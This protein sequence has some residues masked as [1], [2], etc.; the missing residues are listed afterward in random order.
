MSARDELAE[1]YEQWRHWTEEEGMA[2]RIASWR[3]VDECQAAKL[4]LQRLIVRTT[5]Q[6]HDD[7]VGLPSQVEANE[8]FFRRIIDGLI[9][10]ER[11]NLELFANQRQQA[12]HERQSLD[13]TTRH[14]RQIHRSYVRDHSLTEH[15]RSYS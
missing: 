5:E 12:E 10:L 8:R 9:E 11:R 13:R 3:R 7:V 2:I 6:M 1:L 14:L 15:W 4:K